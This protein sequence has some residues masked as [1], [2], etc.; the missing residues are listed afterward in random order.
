M[1]RYTL[2]LGLFSYAFF[3][4]DGPVNGIP[5]SFVQGAIMWEHLNKE[6]SRKLVD[7]IYPK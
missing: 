4:S 7:W 5:E 1:L 2:R 3:Q 6:N